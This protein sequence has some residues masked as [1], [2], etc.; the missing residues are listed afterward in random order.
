MTG[1]VHFC[2]VG[3]DVSEDGL[4]GGNGEGDECSCDFGVLD[5]E[6]GVVGPASVGGPLA[7][8]DE[9]DADG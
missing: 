7:F 4:Q 8:Y 1:C 5:A 3:E 6:H 2:Q 9:P